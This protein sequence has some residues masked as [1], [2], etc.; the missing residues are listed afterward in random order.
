MRIRKKIVYV[1]GGLTSAN[2][3][4]QVLSQKINYLA[5][6]TD[7]KIYMILTEK[8]GTPWF[9]K[10]SDKVQYINFDINFDEL[11]TLPI[12]KKIWYYNKK[13]RKYKK[14]F[15]QYLY[16]IKPDITVSACRREINFINDIK[17][18]SKK[19][20]E[21]HFNKLIYR[22]VNKRY[23]PHFINDSI[24]K[25]WMKQFEKQ[26]KRLNRFVVLSNEDKSYWN[27]I[28]NIEVIY[29]PIKH[30]PDLISDCSSKRAIAVGRY[31]YQK[32]FDLLIKSWKQVEQEHP[33]W[34]L[35]IYGSGDNV[36]FQKLANKENLKTVCCHSTVKDID[37]KYA[38][39]S[40]FLL[41]SRYEGFALVIAEAMSC[42]LPIISFDCPCGP[43]DIIKNF[44]NGFLVNQG[45]YTDFANKICFLINNDSKRKE[46]GLNAKLSTSVFNEDIIMQKWINLFKDL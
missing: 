31:T 10:I 12:I 15:T 14:L 30:F 9:Y 44:K 20:G 28:K 29:N 22:K 18:G 25:L 19:V 13:Q 42:G 26:I 2:G 23:L 3:M 35:D 1:V 40:M 5:E 4:S 33:D 38:E 39:S 11:D 16:D 24:S 27:E 45:D 8:L 32:G 43:K 34:H 17:D 46:F 6:H 7:F 41:S 37:S 21:I 36:L